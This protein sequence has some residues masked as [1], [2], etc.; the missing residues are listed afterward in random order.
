MKVLKKKLKI[1]TNNIYGYEY[2]DGCWEQGRICFV[3]PQYPTPPLQR[4]ACIP[5]NSSTACN[6]CTCF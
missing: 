2:I 4:W 5:W 6:F 1:S 3:I